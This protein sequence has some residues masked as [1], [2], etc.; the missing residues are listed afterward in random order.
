MSTDSSA[1][2]VVGVD[3]VTLSG[4]VVVVRI[5]DGSELASAEHP[6]SHGVVV[7]TLP[8]TG[9]QLP[10]AWA[11]Q[12][13]SDYVD[14]LRHAVPQAVQAA[15]IHP[16]TVIGVGTAFTAC[17]VLPTMD[18]GTPCARSRSSRGARTPMSSCGSITQRSH[19]PTG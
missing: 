1:R 19:K 13:P 7:D 12:V 9:E 16:A 6:Y 10:P 11:L 17:T 18:D 4:R 5:G 15:G 3:F 2:Y 8:S 14:V